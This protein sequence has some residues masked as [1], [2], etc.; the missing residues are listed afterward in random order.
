MDISKISKTNPDGSRR[1]TMKDV[2][3]AVENGT[4]ESDP[5]I[6]KAVQSLKGMKDSIPD[7]SSISRL[8]NPPDIVVRPLPR[9][10]TGEEM[11]ALLERERKA[12]RHMNVW[13][14]VGILA[15]I[16]GTIV[17]IIALIVAIL[18]YVQTSNQ[19]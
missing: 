18:A 17:A 14:K 12:S 16:V 2:K 13:Q 4:A 3:E 1:L 8:L 19:Q 7:L 11:A 15:G 9:P 5:E 10:L 6:Q